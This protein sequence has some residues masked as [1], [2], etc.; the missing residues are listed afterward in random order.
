M[1]AKKMNFMMTNSKILCLC[2]VL[3]VVSCVVSIHAQY[4]A[5]PFHPVYVRFLSHFVCV[6]VAFTMS[7]IQCIESY[8]R[9]TNSV[10]NTH[11]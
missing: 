5:D 3:V 11:K 1:R 4:D 9:V 7:T 10:Q 6:G 8:K 2:A